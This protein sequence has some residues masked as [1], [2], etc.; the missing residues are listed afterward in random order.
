MAGCGAVCYEVD[1]ESVQTEEK[2]VYAGA[3]RGSYQQVSSM[4]MVGRGR[5]DFE[6]EK[7]VVSSGT[8]PDAQGG[9]LRAGAVG[10]SVCLGIVCIFLLI[11]FLNNWWQTPMQA[12]IRAPIVAP[13]PAPEVTHNV[14]QYYYHVKR[15][16][17]EL[18]Q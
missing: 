15:L 4:E 18:K 5:G 9:L 3:G 17:L 11:G 2:L 14:D 6:K 8:P 12:P 7:V 13:A 10:G 1:P 16:D